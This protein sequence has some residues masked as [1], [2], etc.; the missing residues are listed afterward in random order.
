MRSVTTKEEAE[1]PSSEQFEG[2]EK[3]VGNPI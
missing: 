1:I 3:Y 2:I